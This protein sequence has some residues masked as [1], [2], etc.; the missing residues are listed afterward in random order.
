MP[1]GGRGLERDH[2]F[3]EVA[4]VGDL[5]YPPTGGPMIGWLKG[6]LRDREG[7]RAIID[8][9]G[10]GYE[11]F[12][13]SHAL[14]G[15]IADGNEVE[16]HISTQV[17]EDSITL[18]GFASSVERQAFVVLL[19][20]SGIGPKLALACLEGMALPALVRAIETDDI[21][22][23]SKIPGVGKKTAQ[24]L[25]LE[26]KGKLPT[27]LDR[28]PTLTPPDPPATDTLGLA[29]SRLGYSKLEIDHVHEGL[30]RENVGPEVALADRLRVALRL[31]Y[32]NG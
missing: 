30:K 10:V 26:L 29:L 8:V 25:G 21:T 3:L 13:P 18:Y 17:R 2:D 14:D 9:Q 11:I 23:L 6:R 1:A 16:A 22:A 31:L 20:V 4:A 28:R 19:S 32:R 27:A 12:A 15:W 24:R 5:G 7:Q